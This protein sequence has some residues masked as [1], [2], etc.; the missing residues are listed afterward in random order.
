MKN[1]LVAFDLAFATVGAHAR[2]GNAVKEAGKATAEMSKQGTENGKGAVSGQLEKTM[3][4]NK[5]KVHKVT[6]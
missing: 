2:A 1:E 6:G 4:T 3:H 5:A